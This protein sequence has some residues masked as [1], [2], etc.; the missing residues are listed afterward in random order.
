MEVTGRK[1]NKKKIVNL[2]AH[3]SPTKGKSIADTI[4][5]NG[6]WYRNYMVPGFKDR[7]PHAPDFWSVDKFYPY[8]ST[9]GLFVEEPTNEYYTRVAKLKQLAAKEMGLKLVVIEN[10]A[11]LEDALMQLEEI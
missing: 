1:S 7:W 6:F 10:G 5:Q 2:E 8:A 3:L 11:K 9:G 4:A